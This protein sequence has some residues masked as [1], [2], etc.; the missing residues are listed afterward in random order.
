MASPTENR[1]RLMVAGGLAVLVCAMVGLAYASVPLYRAFCEA[2]GFNGVTRR[3]ERAVFT[4]IDRKLTVRFDTNVRGLPWDFEPEQATST[5]QIGKAGLAYFRVK[6]RSDRPIRGRA[7]YN[8]SPEAA[9]AFFIKTQCFCFSDQTI[10]AG[11]E[12]TFP[13]IYYVDPKF[14]KDSSTSALSEIVLSYTFYPVPESPPPAR[15]GG[16]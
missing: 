13:V 16:S 7:A 4:P 6:N 2:T 5:V 11:Q 1:R 12:V 14:A 9:A 8:V 10:A 15:S 3:A